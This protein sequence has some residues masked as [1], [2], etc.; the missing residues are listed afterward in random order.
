[1]TSRTASQAAAT[2]SFSPTGGD[3]GIALTS[4][5]RLPRPSATSCS[6]FR[7]SALHRN[8]NCHEKR[9]GALQLFCAAAAETLATHVQAGRSAARICLSC[10]CPASAAR[11]PGSSTL[12]MQSYEAA[13]ITG[14]RW[15]YEHRLWQGQKYPRKGWCLLVVNNSNRQGREEGCGGMESAE[16]GRA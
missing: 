14:G 6:S 4:T 5:A 2:P 7:S 13:S 15:N 1:M 10:S 3:L 8:Q 12:R 11:H 16:G 9:S